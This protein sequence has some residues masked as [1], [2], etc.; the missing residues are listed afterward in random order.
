VRNN[1]SA[2]SYNDRSTFPASS[3]RRYEAGVG[4]EV[5]GDWY[6]VIPIAE[7]RVVSRWA[8]SAKRPAARCSWRHCAARS[9]RAPRSRIRHVLDKLSAMV[10]TIS[11]DNF[12][13]VICGTLDTTTEAHGR[14]PV[15]PTSC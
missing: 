4:A 2:A 8:T 15:T 10:E 12:A 1:C 7:D 14:A 13:T 9:V 11:D 6:D 3:R 5:G